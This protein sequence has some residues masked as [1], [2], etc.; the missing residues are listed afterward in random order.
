M[1]YPA[2]N[3]TLADALAG[4]NRTALSAKAQAQA[5]STASAA[6]PVSRISVLE[7]QRVIASAIAKLDTLSGTPG[8]AQYAR[9]QF[10][11]QSLDVVAEFTTMRAAMVSLRNWINTNFPRDPGTQAVLTHTYDVDGVP[12]LLTFS[13]VQLDALRTQIATFAATVG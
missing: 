11:N 12:T 1:S 2:S 6:G 8:L 13:T 10:A 9:D 4:I 3:Q 7:L 5:L